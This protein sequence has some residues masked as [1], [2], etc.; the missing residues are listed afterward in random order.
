MGFLRKKKENGQK[1]AIRSTKDT[2]PT[3]PLGGKRTIR[4][5]IATTLEELQIKKHP[6]Q[7]PGL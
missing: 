1:A 2:Y 4:E 6:Q 5:E 7:K 3:T